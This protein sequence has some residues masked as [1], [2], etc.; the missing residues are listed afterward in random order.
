MLTWMNKASCHR[1]AGYK[2]AVE[3]PMEV[4]QRHYFFST[5]ST[6]PCG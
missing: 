5:Q 3:N 2:S 1:S 4:F 6:L